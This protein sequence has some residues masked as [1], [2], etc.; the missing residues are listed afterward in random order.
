LDDNSRLVQLAKSILKI[1]YMP[2]EGVVYP[3]Y[4]RIEKPVVF[5]K[6]EGTTFSVEDIRRFGISIQKI[7]EKYGINAKKLLKPLVTSVK[8]NKLDAYSLYFA[9]LSNTDW[10]RIKNSKSGKP[11]TGQFFSEMCKNAGYDGVIVD[12]FEAF[13]GRHSK[14]ILGYIKLTGRKMKGIEGTKHYIVW[15]SSQ[16]RSAISDESSSHQAFSAS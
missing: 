2:T 13:Y 10:F 12:A 1:K 15:D 14:L 7:A 4:L 9:F 3:V 8:K 6:N 16:I 11:M 5:Q